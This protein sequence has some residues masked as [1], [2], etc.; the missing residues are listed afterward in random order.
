M[1]VQNGF[2]K[3]LS[4]KSA[5]NITNLHSIKRCSVYENR[6]DSIRQFTLKM[7]TKVETLQKVQES[8]YQNGR[9]S[10]RTTI[11]TTT[12]ISTLQNTRHK[13]FREEKQK[14]LKLAIK[15]EHTDVFSHPYA[16][17]YIHVYIYN[18]ILAMYTY[19]CIQT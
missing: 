7:H 4:S 18:C 1:R 11:R 9:T 16:H 5:K 8:K 17:T 14:I 12:S 19:V 2:V 10:T 3:F 6:L 15:M 13:A